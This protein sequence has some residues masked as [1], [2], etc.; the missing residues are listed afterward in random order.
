[1]PVL[2]KNSLR[3][4]QLTLST[5]VIQNQSANDVYGKGVVGCD[6][7]QNIQTQCEQHVEFFNAKPGG[8]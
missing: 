5:S 2:Y 6:I 1:M 3:T 8:M 7:L 4:A